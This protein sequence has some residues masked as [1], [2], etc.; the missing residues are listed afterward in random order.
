M[1]FQAGRMTTR[2]QRQGLAL[3]LMA[4]L[5]AVSMALASAAQAT[6][7][8]AKA[9]GLNNNGQ[10]GD[11]M[12]TGPEKCGAE[13]MACSTTPVPVSGLTGVTAIAAG[14]PFNSLQAFALARREHGTVEAWGGNERGQLGD[15]TKSASSVV[16]VVCA[17]G[18]T[19]PCSEE[20]KQLKE[21][22]AVA[23]GNEHGLAL[24]A[25]GKVM[26]WGSNEGGQLGDGTNEGSLVP[27]EVTGLGGVVAIAAG[28][29][30]SF[31]VLSDGTV[32]A[33]GSDSW[34]SL[35]TGG[36][37]STVPVPVCAIGTKGACPEGPYLSGVKFVSTSGEDSVALLA[38]GTVAALGGLDK[39][40]Q[41]G[42]GTELT[43]GN[44]PV[45][46]TGL[47]GVTAIAEGGTGS[48]GG[49]SFSL[50]RLTDGTVK[51]WGSNHDG[52][53]GVG[54]N[55]GPEMCEEAKLTLCSKTPIAISGL[56]HVKAIAARGE[57]ASALLSGGSVQ[58]WGRNDFGELG[59]GTSTGPEACGYPP[60]EPPRACSTK[61]VEVSKI[62]G[63]SGVGAGGNTSYAFGPP[64][65]VKKLLPT[66]VPVNG[67]TEVTITGTGFDGTTEVKFGSTSAAS[68]TVVSA[69][70]ITA[71][72][73]AELAGSVDVTLTNT[74]G[75][76]PIAL[77][78]R[79]RFTP[80]VTNVSPNT[81]SKA[82]G[83]SVTVTGTGF[84]V[85]TTATKFKF[86]LKAGTS[87]NCTSTTT[88]TVVSPAHAVGTVD[89]KANV[90]T[91][92]SPRNRPG[93]QF[94]YA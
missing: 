77:A 76:S 38:S 82:G 5:A 3:I 87:V 31:A 44:N 68:F 90:N 20:S 61:P 32:R 70:E 7:N 54:T 78:D 23:A 94:T 56:S 13:M 18:A 40:G 15:G 47:S 51:S 29:N 48:N 57:Y 69:T 11:G 89:V 86:G 60:L 16:V 45:A 92:G 75:T 1:D 46:V 6:P 4:L 91:V 67:G 2:S 41:L 64:P 33:W 36:V 79:F 55:T 52:Q 42:N 53:L 85:G 63:A 17:V 27:V 65:A 49:E 43:Q 21:V 28:G 59:D 93:D 9:W 83:T 50:A 26:A 84:V 71:V 8:T 19:S 34:G 35:G 80:T 25:S 88:C 10:L 66:K 30:D 24:L 14:A 81:G 58:S 62:A 39:G 74:W 22:V 72:S 12:T 37:S 73:P